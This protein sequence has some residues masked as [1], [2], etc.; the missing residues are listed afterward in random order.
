MRSPT[1]GVP[2][3]AAEVKLRIVVAF[4]LLSLAAGCGPATPEKA[5][6]KLLELA[7]KDDAKRF[8]QESDKNK[9][10][11]RCRD[12]MSK[13]KE[14][15]DAKDYEQMLKCVVDS[16]VVDQAQDCVRTAKKA[17]REAAKEKKNAGDGAGD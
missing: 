3:Y 10:R 13:A 8:K 15:L 4:S 1:G 12:S 7:E 2:D 14:A 17:A 5:C 11:D 6:D 16:K 9:Y